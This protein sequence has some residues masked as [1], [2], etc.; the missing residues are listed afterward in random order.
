MKNINTLLKE[1]V[2]D[3]MKDNVKT[4]IISIITLIIAVI[5]NFIG[6]IN[7]VEVKIKLPMIIIFI[8]S[9]LVAIII[10]VRLIK[11]HNK[12]KANYEELLNP[13]NENVKAFHP[14]DLVILKIEKDFMNP[15]K[16][17]VNKILRS[18]IICRNGN[19][20]LI[21]Y[22]PE[23]LLTKDETSLILIQNEIAK[24]KIKT[25]DRMF[26]DSIYKKS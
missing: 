2:W 7:S 8:I 11:K 12:L 25:R 23:E 26:W 22:A 5:P 15:T 10:I 24:Q 19:G 6:Q 9:L 1:S 20:I 4:V 16:M 13:F 3:Y 18:E 17:V 14:G 21:N